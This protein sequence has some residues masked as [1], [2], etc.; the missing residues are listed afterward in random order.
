MWSRRSWGSQAG[1]S[2]VCRSQ[3]TGRSIL[4]SCHL[5]TRHKVVLM[6]SRG[7]AVSYQII[8]VLIRLAMLLLTRTRVLG[9]ELA[10]RSG[11]AVVVSNHIAAVDPAILVGVFPRPLV[12]MS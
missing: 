7:L 3:V 1:C 4:S 11:G 6:P 8:R 10:P 5:V 9:R 2:R 12:L